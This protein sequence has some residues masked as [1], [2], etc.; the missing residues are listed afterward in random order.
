MIIR[1]IARWMNVLKNTIVDEPKLVTS[2]IPCVQIDSYSSWMKNPQQ[3]QIFVRMIV[4]LIF[5]AD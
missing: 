1:R 4:Y 5:N 3:L 2:K